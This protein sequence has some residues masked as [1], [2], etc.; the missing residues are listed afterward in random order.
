MYWKGRRRDATSPDRKSL[1][2]GAQEFQGATGKKY[3]NVSTLI[4]S[5]DDIEKSD[6]VPLLLAL[7]VPSPLEL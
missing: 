3:T 7:Y 2:T 1:G 5:S 6:P 4:G